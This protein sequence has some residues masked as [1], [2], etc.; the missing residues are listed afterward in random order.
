MK[1]HFLL[2]PQRKR[3]KKIQTCQNELPHLK[4]PWLLRKVFVID[5]CQYNKTAGN[6]KFTVFAQNKIKSES[7][8]LVVCFL[9]FEESVWGIRDQKR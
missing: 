6:K 7:L 8:R 3:E 1:K 5:D 4:P 9:M 2:R